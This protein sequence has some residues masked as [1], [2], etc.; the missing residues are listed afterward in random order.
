MGWICFFFFLLQFGSETYGVTNIPLRIFSKDFVTPCPSFLSGQKSSQVSLAC[1]SGGQGRETGSCV[2]WHVEPRAASRCHWAR[3]SREPRPTAC[4]VPSNMR[5]QRHGSA[6]SGHGV[7]GVAS[8]SGCEG[9]TKWH[10]GDGHGG[11]RSGMEARAVLAMGEKEAAVR[12]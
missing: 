11:E 10:T 9:T 5:A 1:T 3:G 6:S 4:G 8:R 7:A 12:S 2:Q